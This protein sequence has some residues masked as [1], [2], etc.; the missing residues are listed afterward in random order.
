MAVVVS[1]MLEANVSYI[2]LKANI[3]HESHFTK[4]AQC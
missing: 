2:S 3:H 4:E 1:G